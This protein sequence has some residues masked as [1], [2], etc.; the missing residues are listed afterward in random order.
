M[1]SGIHT[2]GLPV[3]ILCS[4]FCQLDKTLYNRISQNIQEICL[5]GNLIITQVLQTKT[6]YGHSQLGPKKIVNA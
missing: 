1:A 5:Q 2:V 6:L 4:T 3:P